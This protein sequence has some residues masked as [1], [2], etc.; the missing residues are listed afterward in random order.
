MKHQ[1]DAFGRE[2]C[3]YFTGKGGFEVVERDDG[4]VAISG[5]PRCYLAEFKDWPPY[6]RR[7]MRYARGRVLDIGCGAGRVALY[8]QRKGFDVVGVD[9]SPL[10]VKV[11]KQRGLQQAHVVPIEKVGARLGEFDTFLM[12]GNN[13]G[14]FESFDQAR[15]LLRRFHRMSSAKARIIAESRDP[16]QTREP[17]HLAYHRRNRRRG[18]MSGQVRIRIRYKGYATRWFD[19]L[20]VSRGEM[21]EILRGTGWKVSRF[22]GSGGASYIAVIT[23]AGR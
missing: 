7:A 2:I 3:D 15:R 13:F 19:Y 11:C 1:Q 8:L 6:Q 20:L 4:Y 14:L 5:G 18:R 10:A 22:L 16:Y 21:K 17:A 12:M 23:K 9:N